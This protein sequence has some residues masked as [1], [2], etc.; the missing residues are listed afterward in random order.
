MKEDTETTTVIDG[1]KDTTIK[2]TSDESNVNLTVI[3]ASSLSVPITMTVVTTDGTEGMTEEKTE[4]YSTVPMDP[5][6]VAAKSITTKSIL[7]HSTSRTISSKDSESGLT[8]PLSTEDFQSRTLMP[9]SAYNDKT[10]TAS[11][12][13]V[14]EDNTDKLV[15]TEEITI[16]PEQTSEPGLTTRLSTEDSQKRTIQPTS[17]HNDKTI[18][19]KTVFSETTDSNKALTATAIDNDTTPQTL[20]TEA[21]KTVHSRQYSTLS[22]SSQADTFDS[23]IRAGTANTRATTVLDTT[24]SPTDEKVGTQTLDTTTIILNEFE[25]TEAVGVKTSTK[26]SSTTILTSSSAFSRFP[27]DVTT[28]KP[29]ATEAYF[30]EPIIDDE[31]TDSNEIQTESYNDAE[32]FT[33]EYPE[34][35]QQ[36]FTEPLIEDELIYTE[37]AT[38]SF[39]IEFTF[40]DNDTE[41]QQETTKAFQPTTV[42]VTNKDEQSSTISTSLSIST[43]SKSVIHS[44]TAI[45]SSTEN[46][47]SFTQGTEETDGT[48]SS[49]DRDTPS[50][51][52]TTPEV[53]NQLVTSTVSPQKFI[54]STKF[55][56]ET[57]SVSHPTK[58]PYTHFSEPKTTYTILTS[59][60]Q[61]PISST[62]SSPSLSYTST[63]NVFTTESSDLSSNQPISGK[64]NTFFIVNNISC[65]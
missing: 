29:E 50:M 47:T 53:D 21:Y 18:T 44:T 17:A 13:D 26:P 5:S 15:V 23:T 2:T 37:S 57:T 42:S 30:T 33:I 56:V 41:I 40:S 38:S 39:E 1:M 61:P 59:P 14:T 3:T 25:S 32:Q 49:S 60:S 31:F 6:T 64:I 65:Y 36:S 4:A 62:I 24:I 46:A 10:I 8:T 34:T 22:E 48:T 52:T 16:L 12:S 51:S 54:T 35:T 63:K 9:T 43:E 58:S 19:Q 27:E 7:Q 55:N 20:S 28:A 45:S 11:K